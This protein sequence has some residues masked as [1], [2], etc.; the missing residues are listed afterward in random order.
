MEEVCTGEAATPEAQVDACGWLIETAA[1]TALQD[2]ALAHLRRGSALDALGREAEALADFDTALEYDPYLYPAY[3]ARG[4]ALLAGGENFRAIA[5][6]SV[7]AGLEPLSA[8]PYARRGVA[9]FANREYAAAITN[10]ETALTHDADH[11][12]A[13]KALAWVLA[14]APDPALRDGARALALIQ[15]SATAGAPDRMI[16]A[17]ALAETGAKAE[18]MDLY[19]SIGRASAPATARFQRYL[20]AAGFYDG[21]E[22]GVWSDVLSDAV[23]ACLAAGCR[24]GAP[25]PRS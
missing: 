2:Y 10:L 23:R 20:D 5:D 9:L 19:T 21:P 25:R 17:A 3:M 14:S 1:Y 22:D 6:F 13:R 11:T 4:N 8:E 16:L 24:V 18:A 12:A 15:A 7:A